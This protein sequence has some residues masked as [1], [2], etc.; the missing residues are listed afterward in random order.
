ML[1]LT[2][3][4]IVEA[5]TAEEVEPPHSLVS[6]G[7]EHEEPSV[8]TQDWTLL[9]TRSV[10]PAAQV[11]RFGPRAIREEHRSIQIAS[12]LA[13]RTVRNE[14]AF[15]AVKPLRKR[16]LPVPRVNRIPELLLEGPL[17]GSV[18]GHLPDRSLIPLALVD[19]QR[20][21]I[22]EDAHS[23]HV[24]S[25]V[26]QFDFRGT[27]PTSIRPEGTEDS[28]LLLVVRTGL[29]TVRREIDRL[30]IRRQHGSVV[31]ASTV[32]RPFFLNVHPLGV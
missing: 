13:S 16:R 21:L 26:A 14:H 1:R 12:T 31:R 17:P 2:P 25:T 6:V 9:L 15:A 20:F 28:P 3:A 10:D 7:G 32:E 8:R 29:T 5:D 19:Q 24:L 23:G 4:A 11:E 30:S 22:P 27:G 18:L